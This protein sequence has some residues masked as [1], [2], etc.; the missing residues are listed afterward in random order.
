MAELSLGIWLRR[1]RQVM[2]LTQEQLSRQ[3][4]CATITLRKIESDERRPSGQMVERLAEVLA[5]PPADRPAFLRFARGDWTELPT[6]NGGSPPWRAIPTGRSHLPA[7]VTTLIGRE[8]DIA[9]VRGY[10]QD[11][12]IRLV[13]L[14]GPPGI[15][16]ASLGLEAARGLELDF[17]G[18]VFFI[19]LAAV[20]ASLVPTAIA[21]ALGYVEAKAIYTAKQLMESIGD[22]QMLILLANC[23]HLIESVSTLASEFLSACPRLKI[24]ATSRELLRVPGEWVFVVRPLDAPKVTSAVSLQTAFNYPALTLFA[25]RARAVSSDFVLTAENLSAVASICAR[26]D[27]LPLAIELIAARV[28]FMSPQALQKRLSD[29]FVLSADGMRAASARQKTLA[30]AIG[31][32]YDLLRPEEQ[33]LF[34]CLAVFSGGFTLEAAE[35][36]CHSAVADRTVVEVVTSLFDKSLL[37]R[38]SATQGQ[39]RFSMLVTIQRFALSCLRRS[40]DEAEMRGRHLAYFLDLAEHGDAEMRVPLQGEWIDRIENEHDNFRAAL[41]WSVSGGQTEPALRLLKALAWPWE[42]CGYCSETLCWLDKIRTLPD[43]DDYPLIY[44]QVLDHIG[45]C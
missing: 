5:V 29:S 42:A 3:I 23:E 43:I 44:A 8:Q 41:D 9:L 39:D 31:W 26:L 20:D 22:R 28:R 19:G 36:I 40:G 27:G 17:A 37:Q 15:G 21:E 34:A 7:A 2:G 32:S 12:G 14:A 11:P 33:R 24:L 18:G 38:T 35:S 6:Q 25:E 16:K 45:L 13:T 4:G 1:R 30:N 10:L